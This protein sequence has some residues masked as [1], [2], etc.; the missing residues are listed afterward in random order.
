MNLINIYLIE[1]ILLL[2]FWYMLKN[3]FLLYLLLL[4]ECLYNVLYRELFEISVRLLI[5]YRYK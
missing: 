3:G 4:I 2:I 1:C 5:V